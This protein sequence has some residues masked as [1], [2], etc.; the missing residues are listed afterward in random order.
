MTRDDISFLYQ[1][2]VNHFTRAAR[3]A[4]LLPYLDANVGCLWVPCNLVRGR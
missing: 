2:S 3:V 4:R 1:L